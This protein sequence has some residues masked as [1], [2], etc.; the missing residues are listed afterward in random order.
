MAHE[1]LE[2]LEDA[3]AYVDGR[4]EGLRITTVMVRDV[5]GIPKRQDMRRPSSE[6]CPKTPA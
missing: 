4:D 5:Q 6:R 3:R 2:G 1:I